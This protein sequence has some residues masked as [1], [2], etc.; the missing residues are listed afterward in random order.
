MAGFFYEDVGLMKSKKGGVLL[1]HNHDASVLP[2]NHDAGVLPHNHDARPQLLSP[3][4]LL[5]PSY[6]HD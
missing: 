5:L 6:H 4:T 1:P 3:L 2:H